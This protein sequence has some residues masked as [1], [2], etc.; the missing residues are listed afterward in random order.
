M[1]EIKSL[2]DFKK[3]TEEMRK[4]MMND[5]EKDLAVGNYKEAT[6]KLEGMAKMEEEIAKKLKEITNSK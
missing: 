6:F 3:R 1:G 2:E 5:I 4:Q